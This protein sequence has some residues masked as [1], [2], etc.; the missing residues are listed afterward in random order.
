MTAYARLRTPL[1]ALL[2]AVLSAA[3]SGTSATEPERLLADDGV[4]GRYVLELVNGSE[5]PYAFYMVEQPEDYEGARIL[6]GVLVLNTDGTYA[7]SLTVQWTL[8]VNG[9]RQEN[10]FSDRGTYTVGGQGLVLDP[11]EGSPIPAVARAGEITVMF[12]HSEDGAPEM[13]Y[14]FRR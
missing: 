2:A 10:T 4:A 12:S 1:L 7:R 11:Q 3:C 14:T 6:D 13:T 5:L 9:P 8:G